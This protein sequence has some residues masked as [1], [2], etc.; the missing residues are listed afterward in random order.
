[1]KPATVH[2]VLRRAT[3]ALALAGVF[4]LGWRFQFMQLPHG[5]CSPVIRYSAGSILIIDE[6]PVRYQLGDA[7]FFLADDGRIHLASIESVSDTDEYVLVTDNPSCPG[8]D[9][10]LL[11]RVRAERLRGRVILSVNG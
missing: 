9:P 2:R 1:M 8:V 6:H 11:G 3:F 5:H 10:S 7:V 4:Y